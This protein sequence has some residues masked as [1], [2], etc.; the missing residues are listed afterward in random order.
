MTFPVLAGGD[1]GDALPG[2]PFAL[3]GLAAQMGMLAADLLAAGW[4]L[5]TI[6][7]VTW[8]GSAAVAFRA[9]LHE[10]PSRYAAASEAYGRAAAAVSAYANALEEAQAAT[11]RAAELRVAGA[12]AS[13]RWQARAITSPELLVG[14][15]PGW[16]DEQLAVTID[17]T[18]RATL[19]EVATSAA[20][21][22]GAASEE[23]PR[24]PGLFRQI[25]GDRGALIGGPINVAI[26]FAKG[27]LSSAGGLWRMGEL[28]ESETNP[29][30][31]LIDGTPEAHRRDELSALVAA[32][33]EHPAAFVETMG[34]N[35]VAWDEW[36][37]NSEQAAGQILPG[38]LVGMVTDGASVGADGAGEAVEAAGAE[39]ELA[40]SATVQVARQSDIDAVKDVLRGLPK[41]RNPGVWTVG[42]SGDLRQLFVDMT[43]EGR[44]ITWITSWVLFQS[45]RMALRLACVHSR[46]MVARQSTFVLHEGEIS[47]RFTSHDSLGPERI[48]RGCLWPGRLYDWL[49]RGRLRE[50]R[51]AN[52]AHYAGGRPCPSLFRG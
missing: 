15:D 34:K 3:R 2:D 16:A 6:D 17:S 37:K 23:A 36:S 47:G 14:S 5:G 46:G 38:L 18:A 26:G 41:G 22:L 4:E 29:F 11:D 21:V 30:L 31:E 40:E 24:R 1:V 13:R 39:A 28:Y 25:A 48:A 49:H 27:A 42:S 9:A 12:E 19:G 52:W 44:P 32:V 20:A 35:L 8:R 33:T 7:S 50:H 51:P 43:T 10:Q 45:C